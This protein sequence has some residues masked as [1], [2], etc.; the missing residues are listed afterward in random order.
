MI[1][2]EVMVK[3]IGFI[4]WEVYHLTITEAFYMSGTVLDISLKI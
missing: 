4:L 1:I 2:E 3:Y